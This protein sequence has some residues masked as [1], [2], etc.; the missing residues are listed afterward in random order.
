MKHPVGLIR[1][2]DEAASGP[3]VGDG[4]AFLDEPRVDQLPR[5]AGHGGLGQPDSGRD[6]GAGDRA[7]KQHLPEH[8]P[9]VALPQLFTGLGEVHDHRV[10]S[11][12]MRVGSG[13]SSVLSG[14]LLKSAWS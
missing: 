9:A 14:V 11:V 12:R 10:P 13:A 3:A 7:S 1:K 4:V 5:D 2:S 8:Q 6:G